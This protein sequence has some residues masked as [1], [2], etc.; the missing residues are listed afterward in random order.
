VRVG[1]PAAKAAVDMAMWDA[2]GKT[3]GKPVHELL[4]GFTDR[5]RVSHMLGFDDPA[6]V[7]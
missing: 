6:V 7:G 1:N 4:G 3:V 5:L 2:G